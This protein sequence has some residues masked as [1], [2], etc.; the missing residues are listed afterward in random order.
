M[1]TSVVPRPPAGVGENCSDVLWR[2]NDQKKGGTCVALVV[3]DSMLLSTT[4]T[5]GRSW[6]VPS[7][8]AVLQ[9]GSY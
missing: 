6:A 4:S 5:M 3:S 8:L 2:F 1:T 7:V 9:S